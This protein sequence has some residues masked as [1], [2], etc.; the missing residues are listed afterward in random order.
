MVTLISPRRSRL[1]C[2][3]ST[4]GS[5]L[6][7]LTLPILTL[8]V[9]TLPVSVASA[10]DATVDVAAE[11]EKK[12]DQGREL[13]MV[14]GQLDL[15]CK[16]LAESLAL[17]DMAGIATEHR[18]LERAGDLCQRARDTAAR[19]EIEINENAANAHY[20]RVLDWRGEWAKAEDTA[21]DAAGD[22]GVQRSCP[23]NLEGKRLIH[24]PARRQTLPE[25]ARMPL[26]LLSNP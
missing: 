17:M 13:M 16:T 3:V 26:N 11:A 18:D 6:L 4:V 8:A 14:P 24:S 7:V 15:A 23:G 21:T 12:F 5:M 22:L 1:R 20:A 9:L 25:T 2:F 19:Y 10:Q